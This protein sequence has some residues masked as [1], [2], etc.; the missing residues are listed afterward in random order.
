MKIIPESDT[1]MIN[2]MLFDCKIFWG[3]F[4]NVSSVTRLVNM[5]WKAD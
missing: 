5:L 2:A 3:T 4:S 1:M